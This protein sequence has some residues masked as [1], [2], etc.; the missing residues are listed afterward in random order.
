MISGLRP[1]Q[2]RAY[3]MRPSASSSAATRSCLGRPAIHSWVVLAAVGAADGADDQQPGAQ[4]HQPRR[5][6]LSN[7]A[8]AVGDEVEQETDQAEGGF[9][10]IEGVQAEAVSAKVVLEFLD[11]VFALGTAV[12]E[13]P[14]W[15]RV[16]AK[17]G[18]QDM[19][20]I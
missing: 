17:G 2:V 5:L 8:F 14:G 6:I 16:M 15:H 19:K 4:R 12:V 3:S 10:A 1:G 20:G 18:D 11:A 13:P 9:G 7:L